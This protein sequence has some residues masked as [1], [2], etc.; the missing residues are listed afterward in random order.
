MNILIINQP[1]YN[2]G[3]ESAHKG[4]V[5]SLLINLPESRIYVMC[6]L[7]Q[8]ESVRQYSV[9]DSRVK[10]I[11]SPQPV[12]KMGFF[13]KLG[14]QYGMEWMW[15]FHPV[16]AIELR[17]IYKKA[18]VVICAPGGICMGGFQDWNHLFHLRLAKF[19]KK[20]LVYYGRSFGPFPVETKKNRLFKKNSL[21]MLHYFSFLSIR[22]HKTEMLANELGI[23]Y[24]STVDSAFLDSPEVIVPYELRFILEEKYM[25]FVPN[26]LLWHYAYKNKYTHETVMKFYSKV[27]DV[28]WSQNPE[29]NIVMLPQL[30]CGQ[31]YCLRDIEFFRDLADMKNDKRVIVVPDCYSSDVQQ[32]IIKKAEYVIGAR[33]H[34]IVFSLNQAVPCIALSY[35]HKMSGLLESL[36][37]SEWCIDFTSTF[38]NESNQEK[39][40]EDIQRLISQM[41]SDKNIQKMAKEKANGCMNQLVEKLSTMI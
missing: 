19:F 7:S 36:H 38:D 41:K 10:Y 34:S 2:R 4:L 26:Y 14:L 35:E 1:P 37:K 28:V 33:Y 40:L 31:E 5:R 27:M 15:Y 11:T 13:L 9:M 20:P 30:F 6:P 17:K 3:D 39:C 18:D 25:V 16:I 23:P 29:L 32:A 21:E 12:M 8:N 24:I 22:D